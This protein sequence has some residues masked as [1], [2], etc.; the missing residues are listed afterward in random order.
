MLLITVKCALCAVPMYCIPIWLYFW[1]IHNIGSV[2]CISNSA[3][4]QGITL[5]TVHYVLF[6]CI[7]TVLLCAGYH[8][9]NSALCALF[10]YSNSAAVQGIT[11]LTVH[12]VLYAWIVVARHLLG[13]THISMGALPGLYRLVNCSSCTLLNCFNKR[14]S[15]TV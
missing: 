14:N 12:Y 9:V 2:C 3:A 4:V 15:L 10:L 1:P 13:P 5:L 11:L 8:T 7:L 6:L